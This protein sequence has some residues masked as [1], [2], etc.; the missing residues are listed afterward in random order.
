MA[1]LVMDLS[2]HG[3]RGLARPFTAAYFRAAGN[4]EGRSLLPFYTAYR[5]VV[6]AKV[7]GFELVEA[8]IDAAERDAALVRATAIRCWTSANWKVP[9]VGRVSSWSAGFPEELLATP[10]KLIAITALGGL[11]PTT[12]PGR[13]AMDKPHPPDEPWLVSAAGFS[14]ATRSSVPLSTL[15]TARLQQPEQPPIRRSKSG[16]WMSTMRPRT[17]RSR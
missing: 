11:L 9:G 17:T 4:E 13:S 15:T 14:F 7:E 1:F 12:E 5:A 8:E 10:T 2:F 16:R 6:R 3:R